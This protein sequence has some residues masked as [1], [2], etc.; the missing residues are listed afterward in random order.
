MGRKLFKSLNRLKMTIQEQ[1]VRSLKNILSTM[2]VPPDRIDI[3]R[4]NLRW[5]QN[6]LGIQN[7]EHAQFHNAMNHIKFLTILY[8]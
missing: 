7:A 5:M 2:F 3:T 1:Q 4:E 8:A 6:N